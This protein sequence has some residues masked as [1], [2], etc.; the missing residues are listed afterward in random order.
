MIMHE[1]D[2]GGGLKLHVREFGN[3]DGPELFFIHGWSQH[4]LSWSKQFESPL[5]DEF[6][7]V[8]MDLRGHG[9]SEAP[10]GAEHYT[11]GDLWADDVNAVVTT[12][13][14]KRPV[15]A[16]WSY[17]GFVI[18]DY[19]R[20]YGE[21]GIGGINFV[22]AAV[23]VGPPWFGTHIGP[24]FIDNAPDTTLADQP[25]AMR[26]MIRFIH[27][28]VSKPLPAED[29]EA[30]VAWNMLVRPDVRLGL[31][32]R[33]E[34]FRPVLRTIRKPV[35]VTHGREEI[36]VLPKMAEEILEAIPHAEGSW[37]DG[38][39]HAPMLEEPDRFNRE[40]AA[41]ARGIAG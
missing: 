2:G 39:G 20:K 41:F 9:M 40:V 30:A 35:L 6:R 23:V 34:D 4:H 13:G 14:L 37:Y 38:V 27:A 15:L 7:I 19:V 36:V 18:S 17:G 32:S 11:N 33:E 29:M 25:T 5:A 22:G 1:I 10:E 26:A 3:P 28:C 21:A 24:G 16:G 12:L 8:A 31:I